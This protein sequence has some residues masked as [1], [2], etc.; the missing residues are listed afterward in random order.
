MP[1]LESVILPN[2][3]PNLK[4]TILPYRKLTLIAFFAF[5]PQIDRFALPQVTVPIHRL[6]SSQIN[7]FALLSLPHISY[8][9]LPQVTVQINRVTSLSHTLQISRFT[10]PQLSN[11]SKMN[12]FPSDL[13]SAVL[14]CH[15]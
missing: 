3:L 11:R 2:V 15:K 9:T 7:H 8:F 12:R 10:L 4:S 6:A 5:L 1:H 14:P 13:K